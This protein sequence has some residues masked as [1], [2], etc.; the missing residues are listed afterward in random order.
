[1]DVQTL[2][3]ILLGIALVGLGIYRQFVRRAIEPARLLVVPLVLAAY[4]LVQLAKEHT[5][6][7]SLAWLALDVALAVALGVWR[8]RTMRVWRASEG[9]AMA[10]GTTLTAIGWGTSVACRIATAVAGAAL[11]VPVGLGAML[12]AVG[13]TFGAQNAVVIARAK[14]LTPSPDGAARPHRA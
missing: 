13:A 2:A 6:A 3:W 8:A 14:R 10:Q 7:L 9:I 4:G 12:L 5:S 11:G 1:M